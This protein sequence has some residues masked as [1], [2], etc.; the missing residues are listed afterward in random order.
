MLVA[1]G[2][3]D[4]DISAVVE[5]GRGSGAGYDLAE[6]RFPWGWD[7]DVVVGIWYVTADGVEHQA[8][9]PVHRV[10]L[11][12]ASWRSGRRRGPRVFRR[13]AATAMYATGRCDVYP[14][15]VLDSLG[16]EVADALGC[17]DESWGDL[18]ARWEVPV[19]ALVAWYLGFRIGQLLGFGAGRR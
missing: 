16:A 10:R 11:E 17:Y 7:A 14:G 18:A 12:V 2:L 13:H 19:R 3:L 6:T 1:S 8:A 4:G 15:E 5:P 9:G